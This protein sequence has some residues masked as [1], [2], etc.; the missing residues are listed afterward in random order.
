MPRRVEVDLDDAESLD[1]LWHERCR[2][3]ASEQAD[4]GSFRV[5]SLAVDQAERA[6]RLSPGRAEEIRSE[7]RRNHPRVVFCA[8]RRF[9]T[10]VPAES[11]Q[12]SG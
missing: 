3:H 1:R 5:V 4:P 9:W 6:G 12:R 11:G 2:Q 8:F 10:P 7:L